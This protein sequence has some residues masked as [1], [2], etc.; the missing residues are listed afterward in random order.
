ML[1]SGM[2]GQT[3]FWL[4]II[5]IYT[6]V[7][8]CFFSYF[9]SGRATK[10]IEAKNKFAR[11]LWQRPKVFL[12]AGKCCKNTKAG[13][14]PPPLPLSVSLPRP[15]RLAMTVPRVGDAAS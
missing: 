7:S 12:V 8:L 3:Y 15:I 14:F 10:S 5:H 9:G 4:L 6:R 1:G 2:L 11:A 13:T